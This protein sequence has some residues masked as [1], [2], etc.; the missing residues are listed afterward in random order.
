MQTVIRERRPITPLQR[1]ADQVRI[2]NAPG[3]VRKHPKTKA[4]LPPPEFGPPVEIDQLDT[5]LLYRRELAY[6]MC[7]SLRVERWMLEYV[8]AVGIPLDNCLLPV[9]LVPI[10]VEATLKSRILFPDDYMPVEVEEE[11]EVELDVFEARRA[12]L[13]VKRPKRVR[14]PKPNLPGCHG[15]LGANCNNLR[16]YGE[17]FCPS[18]RKKEIDRLRRE[19]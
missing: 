1:A 9:L 4:P 16:R 19:A 6:A 11:E 3:A 17:K 18:C 2:D 7:M 5:H 13:T 12:G 14:K 15:F 8:A 10:Y